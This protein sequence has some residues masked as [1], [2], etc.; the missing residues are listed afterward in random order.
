M[1]R[2]VSLWGSPWGLGITG[3]YRCKEDLVKETVKIRD[4][5]FSN[6]IYLTLYFTINSEKSK[7]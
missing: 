2:S 1:H 6:S 3:Y 7:L 5:T 4:L